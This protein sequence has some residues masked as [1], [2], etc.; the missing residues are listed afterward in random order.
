MSRFGPPSARATSARDERDHLGAYV[1]PDPLDLVFTNSRGRPV[2]ATVWTPAWAKAV[3]TSGRDIRLHD[4]RHLAETLTAQAGATLKETMACLGH[5]TP[6]A[7][8]RYQ[9][10]ATS[11]PE[12]IAAGI[13]ALARS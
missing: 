8:L 12:T 11:R 9:H 10:I 1:G 7:A 3:V 2:R 5:S 6:D 4:L 13:D